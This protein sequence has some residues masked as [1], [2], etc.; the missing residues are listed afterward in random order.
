MV[1]GLT[2]GIGS[3]KSTV[4]K[5]FQKLGAAVYIADI[6]AKKIMNS[7]DVLKGE[8]KSIFGE[9]AYTEG[10]LNRAYISSIVFKNPEKL[11]LLN[12]VVHPAVRKDFFE[13][14]QNNKAAYIVYE[15]AILF[16]SNNYQFC[17]AVVLVVAPKQLRVDRILKRE[18]ITKEQIEA[19]MNNQLSDE[20]KIAKSDFV[21]E[22]IDLTKVKN[23]VLILHAKFLNSSAIK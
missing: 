23:E 19:R 8:I 15:S 13:F 16:E 18:S 5:M 10:T 12:K 4:L 14:V 17:D 20:E 1:V 21:I 9:E 7:S 11:K 22:N 3:G 2:G 6:E